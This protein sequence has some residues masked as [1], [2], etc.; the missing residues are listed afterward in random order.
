MP[1]EA[2]IMTKARFLAREDDG[3]GEAIGNCVSKGT[4]DLTL[5][6][7][8]VCRVPS[9]QSTTH[10]RSFF[11]EI[12]ARDNPTAT[13]VE[14][15]AASWAGRC[16]A[17]LHISIHGTN[18]FYR[19]SKE[20]RLSLKHRV[21]LRAKQDLKMDVCNHWSDWILRFAHG[22]YFTYFPFEYLLLVMKLLWVNVDFIGMGT[23][24]CFNHPSPD[25]TLSKPVK[26][27]LCDFDNCFFF[28]QDFFVESTYKYSRTRRTSN[29]HDVNKTPFVGLNN[30][31]L[32]QLL[33]WLHVNV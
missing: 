27:Y 29:H 24:A 15:L 30:C 3:L 28:C 22:Y 17:N 25:P 4:S 20:R 16:F 26:C 21:L 12:L 5:L 10:Q 23:K 33:S 6:L 31:W 32:L 13:A 1:F 2:P 9:L 11:P 19:L 14:A 7:F 18:W 8:C